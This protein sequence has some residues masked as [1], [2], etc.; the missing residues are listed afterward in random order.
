M[1]NCLRKVVIGKFSSV[2]LGSHRRYHI[3]GVLYIFGD[4][5]FP[6]TVI[7][8]WVGVTQFL[9]IGAVKMF[10]HQVKKGVVAQ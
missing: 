2:V 6:R 7:I 8:H 1:E 5:I 9:K 4:V 10:G 3:V